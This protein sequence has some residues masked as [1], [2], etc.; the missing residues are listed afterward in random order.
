MLLKLQNTTIID[1]GDKKMN[2]FAQVNSS[3][4]MG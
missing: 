4:A 1:R 2:V 3:D